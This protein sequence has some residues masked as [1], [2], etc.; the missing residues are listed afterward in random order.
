MTARPG[1]SQRPIF[2]MFMTDIKLIRSINYKSFIQKLLA[3]GAVSHLLGNI[4]ATCV[5]SFVS[6]NNYPGGVAM[7]NIHRLESSSTSK[8]FCITSVLNVMVDKFL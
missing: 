7:M 8:L 2:L 6:H 4:I 1:L 5:F 3:L